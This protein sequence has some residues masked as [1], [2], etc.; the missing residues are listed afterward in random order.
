MLADTPTERVLTD[1][2]FVR[3]EITYNYEGNTRTRLPVFL[4]MC[5]TINRAVKIK[6]YKVAAAPVLFVVWVRD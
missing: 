2:K 3:C 5:G 1:F 6:L 4:Q